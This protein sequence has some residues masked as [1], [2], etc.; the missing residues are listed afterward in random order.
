MRG[1]EHVRKRN[2]K[3]RDVLPRVFKEI[4]K[5][6]K[7]DSEAKFSMLLVG[8]CLNRLNEHK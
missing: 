8:K 4:K 7:Y 6:E 2:S 5:G 1:T 3:A